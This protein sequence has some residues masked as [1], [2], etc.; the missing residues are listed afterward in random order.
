MK[1]ILEAEKSTLLDSIVLMIWCKL[2]AVL[3]INY[4]KRVLTFYSLNHI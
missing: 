4:Y 2:I 1:Y 3:S